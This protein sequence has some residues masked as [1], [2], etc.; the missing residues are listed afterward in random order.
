M[1]SMLL[2]MVVG[3]GQQLQ[4]VPICLWQWFPNNSAL[5]NFMSQNCLPGAEVSVFTMM[6]GGNT[7]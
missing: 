1:E 2:A 6:V 7:F 3:S 4:E 5:L